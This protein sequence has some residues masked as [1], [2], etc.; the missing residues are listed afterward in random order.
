MRE[1]QV[2]A[3]AGINHSGDI[4]LAKKL[5]DIAVLG[6]CQFI[7]FQKRTVEDVYSKEDLDKPRES[8]W[9]STNREQKNGIELKKEDY[10][11]IDRYCREKGIQW[12]LSPW[13]CKS[14]DFL[15]QYDLPFIKVASAS[16]TDIE[17]LNKIKE[18]GKPVIVSTG[19]T[20][21]EELD[22]LLGI[23]GDQVK[24]ILSCTATYPSKEEDMNMNRIKTLQK[25]YGDKYKIGFSNHS[26]GIVFILQACAMGAEMVEFHI[27]NDRAQYGSDQAASVET[28]GVLMIG[29]DIKA[30][31][32]GMGD[33]KI[34]CLENEKP[35]RDKLRK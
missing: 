23:F 29:K 32:N 35:I 5:I 14:V 31:I 24:Y 18:T 7:K 21:Q 9:G 33:G 25:L 1:V 11:E 20:S 27:T 4:N 17:L 15:M 2:V 28:P 10:D 26:S 16:N 13:D 8:P 12:F 19:M 30:M 22:N 6:Q 3:E 34:G